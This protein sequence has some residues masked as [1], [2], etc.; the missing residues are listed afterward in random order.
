MSNSPNLAL[1]YLVAQQAQKEIT[2]NDAL[3]MLDALA[4]I[5][6]KDRTL[7]T[8]PGSP[9]EGDCYIV[10]VSATGAWSGQT[11]NI[12]C[13]YSGWIFKTP[14]EGWLAYVR[15]ED[16]VYAYDGSSWAAYKVM[17]PLGSASAPALFVTGDTN[18]GLFSGGADQLGI[19]TNGAQRL[20]ADAN[21]NVVIN[22]AALATSATNGFLYIPT[23]AGTPTGS[24]TSYSGRAPLVL[25]TANNRLYLHNGSAW[26][27]AVLL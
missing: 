16:A 21:G 25:D 4:Q 27:Y 3:N 12:A 19:A 11:G 13:Y 17:V 22:T 24:P 2:H 20:N 6:V 1:P 7:T 15:N 23:C 10:P 8:P 5:S 14:E 18:T 26:K 9:A